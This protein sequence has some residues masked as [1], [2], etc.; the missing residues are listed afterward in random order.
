MRAG[1]KILEM[2][3]ADGQQGQ[4]GGGT[5]GVT[6]ERFQGGLGI[7]EI[8]LRHGQSLNLQH[9]LILRL[10]GNT[11]VQVRMP[12]GR[13]FGQTTQFFEGLGD[14]TAAGGHPVGPAKAAGQGERIGA[15]GQ[16]AGEIIASEFD[17]AQEQHPFPI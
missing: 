11:V 14:H 3:F 1:G 5:G 13:G 15:G 10:G 9:G 16:G 7:G 4:I 12:G 17:L 8:G 2:Q 6:V